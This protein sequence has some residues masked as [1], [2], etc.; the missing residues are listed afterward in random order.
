M[1][2]PLD[3]V[4]CAVS[5]QLFRWLRRCH[6]VG[7]QL[8][9][10]VFN[11]TPALQAAFYSSSQQEEK[12]PFQ[13]FLHRDIQ[14]LLR[15]ITGFD[16]MKITQPKPTPLSKP[17]YKL[18]TDEELE[19]IGQKA[20]RR[21]KQRLQMPPYMGMRQPITEVLTQDPD[22][23]GLET[24]KLVFTDITFGV[25]DRSR[26]IVVRDPNGTLRKASWEERDKINQIYNPREGRM[27]V[28]PQMFLD[29]NLENLLKKKKYA[30]I[31][32][33]ACVQ[34]EPDHPDYIRI[35]HRC[36]QSVHDQRDYDDLR[37][38]RHFGPVAFHLVWN[39]QIDYLL[40]DMLLR[41]LAHDAAYLVNIYHLVH[42]QSSSA[43]YC[44]ENH[45]EDVIKVYLE[46]EC[47]H[48]A[49][50]ELAIQSVDPEKARAAKAEA[51]RRYT[52]LYPRSTPD[53]VTTDVQ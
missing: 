9:S 50:L 32:D 14:R 49:E 25:S 18:L 13:V 41:N 42:T 33:R 7:A 3:K 16:I 47:K 53:P 36:Y 17:K 31:L 35:T 40:I 11:R 24:S 51:I 44:R 48:K 37:S 45:E 38:T 8:R 10:S 12:D 52:T 30:Y 20:L 46:H 27:L 15:R 4:M 5:S 28:M 2:A 1:A 19:Q 34:F 6:P 26:L 29:E 21:A 23:E 39:K 43:V 22:L